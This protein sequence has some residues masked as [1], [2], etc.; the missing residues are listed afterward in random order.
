[1]GEAVAVPGFYNA[2]G[3]GGV[4]LQLSPALGAIVADLLTKGG[5]D[6]LPDLAGYRLER[7]EGAPHR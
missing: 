3:G 2:V 1:V 7:F 5:T 6:V 4:G